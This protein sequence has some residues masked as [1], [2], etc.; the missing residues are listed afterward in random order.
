M[1]YNA[2]ADLIVF[3]IEK[4]TDVLLVS[5]WKKKNMHDHTWKFGTI[6]FVILCQLDI[7]DILVTFGI[8]SN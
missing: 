6:A 3:N 4:I 7:I 2:I 1:I 5:L 8:S